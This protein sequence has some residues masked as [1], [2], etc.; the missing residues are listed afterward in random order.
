MAI[1]A[2]GPGSTTTKD[3]R[4]TV[5][6]F[7]DENGKGTFS[8]TYLPIPNTLVVAKWNQ[9]GHMSREVK[10]T[11]QDGQ[12]EFSVAYTHFFDVSVVPPCGY[13]PT[14]PLFRDVTA[15]EKAEFGFWP[16]SPAEQLSQLKVLLWQ[17]RNADGKRDPEEGVVNEK[18]GLMF[19]VPGGT[20]GNVYDQNNFVS[21]SENGWFDFNLGNSCGTVYMLLLNSSMTSNSVS[22]PGRVSDAGAHGNTFYPSIEIPYNPGATKIYWEVGSK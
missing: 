19:K 12:T 13:Y 10:L 6:T 1:L 21:E 22:E 8:E 16:A 17:D 5:T 14:S 4:L 9:H 2:C 18:A 20:D 7:V 3:A 11:D 15:T